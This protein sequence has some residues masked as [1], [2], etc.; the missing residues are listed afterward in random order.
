MVT[1]KLLPEAISWESVEKGK[2]AINFGLRQPVLCPR[3]TSP[4]IGST[5]TK[6]NSGKITITDPDSPVVH[7]HLK[8]LNKIP[9]ELLR[10]M[11]N[12]G[13]NIRIGNG[14]ILDLANNPSR[15]TGL[16]PRGWK[17]NGFDGVPGAYLGDEHRA[18][19][20]AGREHIHPSLLL[21]EFGHAFC[22]S[23]GLNGDPVTRQAHQQNLPQ[24]AEYYKQPDDAGVREFGAEA[25]AQ[26]LLLGP[27]PFMRRY[28]QEWGHYLMNRINKF[29]QAPVFPLSR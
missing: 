25:V 23:S 21:H 13:T 11:L 29:T 12:A 19:A 14:D 24:L 3:D 9:P 18:Y 2:P 17:Q 26:L 22:D 6:A 28:G 27:D 7:Q 1:T 20:G 5:D 4:R 15:F 8:D 16:H 10:A